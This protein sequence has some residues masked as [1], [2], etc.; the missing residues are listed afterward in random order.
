MKSL[1]LHLY[2]FLLIYLYTFICIFG[3]AMAQHS[4]DIECIIKGIIIAITCAFINFLLYLDAK[5]I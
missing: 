3:V 4:H 5:K 2:I 1:L